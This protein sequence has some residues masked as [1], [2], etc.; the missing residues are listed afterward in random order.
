MRNG[1]VKVGDWVQAAKG[2]EITDGD[3]RVR[4]GTTG[5]VLEVPADEMA[6]VMV[7]WEGDVIC[8]ADP[9]EF[10][11]LC[12]VDF[13]KTPGTTPKKPRREPLKRGAA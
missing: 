6:F 9:I 12:D 11:V 13:A 5:Q 1:E 8:G 4:P 7:A 3:L 2:S 10:D